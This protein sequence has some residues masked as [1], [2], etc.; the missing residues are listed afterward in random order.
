MTIAQA[1][2]KAKIEADKAVPF[3]PARPPPNFVPTPADKVAALKIVVGNTIDVI[4]I[5]STLL[6]LLTL[7]LYNL[8]LL[9]YRFYCGWPH[10]CFTYNSASK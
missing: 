5:N 10:K 8:I 3:V 2:Q 4:Q 9:R 1:V 7:S 6:F